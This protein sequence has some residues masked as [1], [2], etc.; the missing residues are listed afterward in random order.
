MTLTV[1][2]HHAFSIIQG[3]LEN[4]QALQQSSQL[5]R[6]ELPECHRH[7]QPLLE[8]VFKHETEA[9][10]WYKENQYKLGRFTRGTPESDSNPLYNRESLSKP[11]HVSDFLSLLRLH[12]QENYLLSVC[13][14]L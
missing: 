3:D 5:W 1:H 13:A 12:R 9:M 2:I 14:C 10:G 6:K 4:E 7:Q 8:L 11:C